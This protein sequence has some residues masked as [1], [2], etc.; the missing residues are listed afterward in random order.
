MVAGVAWHFPPTKK[1]VADSASGSRLIRP[2][3]RG[4]QAA[5][6]L[7]HLSDLSELRQEVTALGASVAEQQSTFNALFQGWRVSGAVP[8]S[9]YTLQGL[10]CACSVTCALIW[11][12]AAAGH[13]ADNVTTAGLSDV[14]RLCA[15]TSS[16]GHVT[17][18]PNKNMFRLLK[19]YQLRPRQVQLQLLTQRQ[20]SGPALTRCCLSMLTRPCGLDR[21]EGCQAY[22]RCLC[23]LSRH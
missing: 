9:G 2:H 15:A 21:Y 11:C 22:V 10:A 8:A 16:A 6:K 23:K 4:A 5:P 20:M 12:P 1:S 3:K 19:P 13:A 17:E 14:E 7:D 18:W